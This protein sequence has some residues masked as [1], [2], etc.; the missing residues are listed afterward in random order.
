[1]PKANC[2][3]LFI[4]DLNIH[5]FC[6]PHGFWNHYLVDM[7]GGSTPTNNSWEIQLILTLIWTHGILSLL[8]LAIPEKVADI[9]YVILVSISLLVNYVEHLFT[10]SV[11]CL[12]LWSV[13]FQSSFFFK[14]I[15]NKSWLLDILR[16]SF[17]SICFVYFLNA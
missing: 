12:L 6:Y 5:G 17:P 4:R 14:K 16:I 11:A 8:I 9:P 10:F 13:C 7:E 1:M 2:T 3:L 15:L